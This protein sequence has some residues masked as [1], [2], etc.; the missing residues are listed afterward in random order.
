MRCILIAILLI[1]ILI[2][3]TAADAEKM[4]TIGWMF[5]TKSDRITA[6][7]E[8]TRA[9]AELERVRAEL[10]RARADAE[11]IRAEARISERQSDALISIATGTDRRSEN[12]QAM[13]QGW[14]VAAAVFAVCCLLLAVYGLMQRGRAAR[15]EA[16]AHRLYDDFHVTETLDYRRSVSADHFEDRERI[17][18][19]D[20]GR[21]RDLSRIGYGRERGR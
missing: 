1:S 2:V 17:T 11:R 3:G 18:D 13:A 6:E 9:D 19:R 20:Q 16:I 8:R 21:D 14:F 10:E 5:E 7:A 12:Y 4:W 15:Y